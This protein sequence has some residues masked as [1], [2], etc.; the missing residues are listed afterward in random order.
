MPKPRNLN[1]AYRFAAGVVRPVLM[2]ATRRDWTGYEHFPAEGGFIVCPNH[3]SHADPLLLAHYVFDSGRAPYFLAKES[4]FRIPVI[5]K[6]IAKA[7][8]IPVYR[9]SG[10]A[11]DAFRAAIQAIRDGKVVVIY[12][13]GTITRD[14][15]IWPMTGKTGAARIALETGCPV[16]PVAQWGAQ[17]IIAPYDKKIAVLPRKTIRMRAGAPVDL[18]DLADQP[19]TPAVLKEAT[20]RIMAAVTRE[21]EVLRGE[22]AP[23][24]R[25]DARTSG[26]PRIGRPGDRRGG[27]DRRGGSGRRD[28]RRRFGRGR[29]VSG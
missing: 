1:S 22:P 27:R 16:I 10:Q 23:A 20:D 8:Q 9:E 19:R 3:I 25:F 13:E 26:V 28:G 18:A 2:R 14:P 7:D 4:V 21:L 11:A 12:P 6:I 24:E 15:G 17:E 29:K 5:G